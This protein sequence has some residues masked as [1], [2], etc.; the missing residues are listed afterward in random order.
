[1]KR[2]KGRFFPHAVTVLKYLD[3]NARPINSVTLKTQ[4]KRTALVRRDSIP[5]DCIPCRVLPAPQKA[6]KKKK[7]NPTE[8]TIIKIIVGG[9]IQPHRT[10]T[11][12]KISYHFSPT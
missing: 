8:K 6:R 3:H 10:T 2:S 4:A 12:D 1:M 11:Q 9:T 5:G 7:K